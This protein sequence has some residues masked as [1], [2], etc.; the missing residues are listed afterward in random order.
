VANHLEYWQAAFQAGDLEATPDE[1]TKIHCRREGNGADG[2]TSL[3]SVLRP[4]CADQR[5]QTVK[6]AVLCRRRLQVVNP[7]MIHCCRQHIR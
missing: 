2:G 5:P 3:R 4:A 6:A 1:P 7:T